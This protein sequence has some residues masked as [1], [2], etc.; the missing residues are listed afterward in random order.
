MCNFQMVITRTDCNATVRKLMFN[1][2]GW[3]H[4]SVS[5]MKCIQWQ[6]HSCFIILDSLQ[7]LPPIWSHR[8][9]VLMV[10]PKLRGSLIQRR[11]RM[12]R[13]FCCCCCCWMSQIY[14]ISV[15]L[16]SQLWCNIQTWL[17]SFQLKMLHESLTKLCWKIPIFWI[18]HIWKKKYQRDY[19]NVRSL[20][21]YEVRRREGK[22]TTREK[23][24]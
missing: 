2:P 22:G 18:A 10:S 15:I 7:N 16:E 9:Y 11:Y 24:K 8:R 23:K 12:Y 20:T 14:E 19:T 13:C 21:V 4:A 3:T 17:F 5:V 6:T 1:K